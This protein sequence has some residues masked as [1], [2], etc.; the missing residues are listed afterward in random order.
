MKREKYRIQGGSYVRKLTLRDIYDAGQKLA[1][2]QHISFQ[3]KKSQSVGDLWWGRAALRALLVEPSPLLE[4]G[5]RVAHKLIEAISESIAE[6]A[7]EAFKFG[8]DDTLGYDG[9]NINNIFREFESVVSNEMPGVP[10]YIVSKKGIYSTDDLISRAIGYFPLSIQTHIPEQAR[11]DICEAGKCLA[12]ELP[13]ACSFH[14]WRAVEETMCAY[15]FSLTGKTAEAGIKNK[16][17]GTII[18]AL[19][20]RDA[21]KSV[22]S[23]L[24]HIRE[25]YRNPQL[26]PEVMV[27]LDEALSMFGAAA[28][29]INQ[30]IMAIQKLEESPN[31]SL[32]PAP[33]PALPSPA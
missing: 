17:W 21:D 14:L 6:E 2:L 30:Q 12:F 33:A 5:Q 26:H 25:A 31:L 20:E 27:T 22:T 18:K 15:Y 23:F 24:N 10:A 8:D 29:C 28:S 16:N 32:L 4:V 19:E 1:P 7:A 9:W 13:T 11:L 3:T